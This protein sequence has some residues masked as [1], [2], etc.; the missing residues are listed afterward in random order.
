MDL[1]NTINIVKFDTRRME[2]IV[3]YQKKVQ[4]QLDLNFRSMVIG[5]D[6]YKYYIMVAFPNC[7]IGFDYRNQ[8]FEP[9][10]STNYAYSV[11]LELFRPM[12]NFRFDYKFYEV[13]CN[14]KCIHPSVIF[15]NNINR[16]YN[17]QLSFGLNSYSFKVN[18]FVDF[19]KSHRRSCPEN[20]TVLFYM[21][22]PSIPM[23]IE[24]V[25]APERDENKEIMFHQTR[26]QRDQVDIIKSKTKLYLEK[27]LRSFVVSILPNGKLVL[28][29][30]DYLPYSLTKV[31]PLAA[32]G[33]DLEVKLNHDS[34]FL[35]PKTLSNSSIFAGIINRK[36]SGLDML[37]IVLIQ[38]GR[39]VLFSNLLQTSSFHND[40]ASV[41]KFSYINR[42]E[43]VRR[44]VNFD[45]Q[46]KK[47]AT[48]EFDFLIENKDQL[49]RYYLQELGLHFNFEDDFQFEDFD[50]YWNYIRQ[51]Q[52]KLE[53]SLKGNDVLN[54]GSQ[55]SQ[56]DSQIF[57]GHFMF[58]EKKNLME[59]LALKGE[60]TR[61][62]D[63]LLRVAN[64]LSQLGGNEDQLA[65]V[66][67]AHDALLPDLP[68]PLHLDHLRLHQLRGGGQEQAI[69]PNRG[70]P[71][72][73]RGRAADFPEELPPKPLFGLPPSRLG[74]EVSGGGPE[75]G[76]LRRLVP[77][78]RIGRG[79]R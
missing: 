67:P 10:Y 53:K 36:P 19:S 45:F 11:N 21:D 35:F 50:N 29:F 70:A 60:M 47:G 63:G 62:R 2:R 58:R 18:N 52:K 14:F 77:R 25:Q 4:H 31:Q 9:D 22:V 6:Y 46:I 17:F 75:E 12:T 40:Q 66:A 28:P 76:L 8:T 64:G 7:I 69:R 26:P 15:F 41:R 16:F 44:G 38:G 34:R 55:D 24:P 73:L 56:C 42:D 72:R 39:N 32:E 33:F 27:T 78:R 1:D 3:Y 59:L 37:N 13:F 48:S 57:K 68:L 61:K 20:K 43:R 51:Q 30:R 71:Q 49:A 54:F 5:S 65:Q 79:Q 74:A 23:A